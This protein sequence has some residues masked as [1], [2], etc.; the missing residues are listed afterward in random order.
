MRWSWRIVRVFGIGIRLHISFLVLPLWA[1][2]SGY[3]ERNSWG[4]ASIALAFILLLFV[5]VVLHELGHCLTARRFGIST[6]DITLLPIGGVARLDRMPE[7]PSQ[8][9]LVALAGPAVNVA[10]ASLMFGLLMLVGDTG[11]MPFIGVEGIG[12]FASFMWVNVG[13]AIFN[14]VPAF[15]MDGGRVLRAL[16]AIKLPYVQATNA[17]AAVGQGIAF[18]F[19]VIGL[20]S[21]LFGHFGPVSNPF[22]LFVALFVWV[23]ARQEAG[24]VQMRST[25]EG[26]PLNSLMMKD[27]RIISPWDSLFRAAEQLLAG[28]QEVFPVVEHGRLSGV[29][30]RNQLVDGLAQKGASATVGEVME[31]DFPQIDPDATASSVLAALRK[32]GAPFMMVSREGNLKGIITRESIST[33]LLVRSALGGSFAIE[34]NPSDIEQRRAA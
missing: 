16:L 34:S 20:S 13:L 30:T 29:L 31:R 3:S 21:V 24:A 12:F 4:D 6:R 7:K 15:P 26:V 18:L 22:L 17:A 27:F 11:E 2:W 8:E 10:V 28:S 14:L 1:A 19:G 33:F 5:V 23:G 9:L 25:L 32:S